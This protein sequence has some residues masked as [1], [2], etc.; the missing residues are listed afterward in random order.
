[1]DNTLACSVDLEKEFVLDT[2]NQIAN[3]FSQTRYNPWPS[4]K[5]FIDSLPSKSIVL[6]AGCGNGKNM[7]IRDDLNFIGIDT[8][9]NLL[10]ICQERGLNVKMS[11]IKSIPFESNYFD[12]IVCI[13]VLHHI[14]TFEDR[15]QAMNELIRVL[16]PGGQMMIQVWAR[17]QTLSAQ[18]IPFNDQNDYFVTWTKVKKSG[19]KE[20][21]KRYYHLF[22]ESEVDELLLKLN[23]IKI[24]KKFY[25]ANNWC[26]IIE[27]IN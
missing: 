9:E 8:S 5:T 14:S 7:N 1:M 17:E 24:I 22:P 11:N 15:I 4:V 12:Y 19:E 26:F 21:S 2:Y 27:K 20:I 6:D 23:G 13:A 18:F 3:E 16:K 10:K 25:E